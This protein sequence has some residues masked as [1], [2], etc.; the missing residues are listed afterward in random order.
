VVLR[1]LIGVVGGML[2]LTLAG[3]ALAVRDWQIG[4]QSTPDDGELFILVGFGLAFGILVPSVMIRPSRFGL[5]A[6]ATLVVAFYLV[7]GSTRELTAG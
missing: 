7:F 6:I 5:G 2:G 1:T 3:F 4:M